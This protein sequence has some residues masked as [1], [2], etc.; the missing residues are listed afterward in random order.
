M[1]GMKI[2]ITGVAGFSGSQ[3]DLKG[4]WIVSILCKT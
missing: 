1:G 4:D 3:R 2:Y